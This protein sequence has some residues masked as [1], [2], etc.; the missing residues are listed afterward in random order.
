MNHEKQQTEV[1]QMIE[2]LVCE[3]LSDEKYCQYHSAV[4]EFV[5]IAV[6][7]GTFFLPMDL[8]CKYKGFVG[9]FC[10]MFQNMQSDNQAKLP[11]V[12]WK[13]M[14]HCYRIQA[15]MQY[16]IL[17]RLIVPAYQKTTIPEERET[18]KSVIDGIHNIT[19]G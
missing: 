6:K 2:T 19:R 9:L 18:L 7:E 4:L 1:K 8:Y 16:R 3:D 13:D 15:E 11:F 17:C 14:Y 10:K 12:D 5:S